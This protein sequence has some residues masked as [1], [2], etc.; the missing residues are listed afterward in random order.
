[1]Y[2]QIIDEAISKI[3]VNRQREIEIAKQKAMQEQIAPF[4][5]DIDNSLREAIAELQNKHNAKITQMQQAFEAEKHALAEA[6]NNKKSSFAET[7]IATAVLAINAN[8]DTTIAKL[9]EFIGEGA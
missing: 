6:A 9:R 2:K 4:N 5:R 3:E 7:T 8:A 1:M